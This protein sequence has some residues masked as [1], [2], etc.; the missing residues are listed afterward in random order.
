M[1]ETSPD[2]SPFV[3]WESSHEMVRQTLAA[4]YESLPAARWGDVDVTDAYHRVRRRVFADCRRVE[5]WGKPGEAYL[6][7][8]LSVHGIAPWGKSAS[9]PPDGRIICYFRPEIGGPLQWLTNP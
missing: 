5:I 6:A 3:I 1:I 4:C 2:A 9:A 7:H 8:R